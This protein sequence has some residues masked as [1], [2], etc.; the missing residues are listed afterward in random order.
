MNQDRWLFQHVLNLDNGKT[1]FGLNI[2]FA[3]KRRAVKQSWLD[4]NQIKTV[5]VKVKQRATNLKNGEK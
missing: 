5:F 4:S 2:C 3:Y 1:T